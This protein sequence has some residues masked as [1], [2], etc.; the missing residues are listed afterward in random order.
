M[1]KTL[2]LLLLFIS[3]NSKAQT[4]CIY[5]ISGKVIDA[6]SKTTLPFARVELM[7]AGK[8][9]VCNENGEFVFNEL[10]AG[11]VEL[12]SYY[13]GFDT[14]I[15]SISLRK[16]IEVKLR[17]MT[18]S[19]ELKQTEVVAEHSEGK[20]TQ[21]KDSVSQIEMRKSAGLSLTSYLKNVTGVTGMSTG[22]SIVKPHLPIIGKTRI[23]HHLPNARLGKPFKNGALDVNTCFFRRIAKVRL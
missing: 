20:N 12:K 1:H 7:P 3:M 8:I 22:S 21:L 16:N 6:Q 18:T 23:S 10:C 5:R 11:D 4:N 19:K 2:C 9:V 13:I 15:Q 17:L 14:L